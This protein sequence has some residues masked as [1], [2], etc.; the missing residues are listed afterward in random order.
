MCAWALLRQTPDCV[1]LMRFLLFLGVLADSCH[2]WPH[3]RGCT[4]TGTHTHAST[5]AHTHTR[6]RAHT[7]THTQMRTHTHH[8]ASCNPSHVLSRPC[9]YIYVYTPFSQSHPSH[10]RPFHILPLF[11]QLCPGHIGHEHTSAAAQVISLLLIENLHVLVRHVRQLDILLC[12]PTHN[13]HAPPAAVARATAAAAAA[14]SAAWRHRQQP[15]NQ[16][17][18][19]KQLL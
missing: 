12:N 7:H 6:A 4:C 14:A 5:H 19:V 3:P 17:N 16:H 15:Q 1:K 2:H 11:L 9:S 13:A 10:S 18:T 8:P